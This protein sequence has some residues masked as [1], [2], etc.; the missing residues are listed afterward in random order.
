MALPRFP[1]PLFPPDGKV[2]AGRRERGAVPA[3]SRSPRV[4]ILSASVGAGH[5]RAAQA[6]EAAFAAS[7][8]P[9]EAKH[10]DVLRF[11]NPAFRTL[12]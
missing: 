6:L 8:F 2:S 7:T 11:T 1:D 9:G 3:F 5:V 4:L 12:Y 10:L